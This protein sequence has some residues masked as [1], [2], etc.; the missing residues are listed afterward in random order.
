L[1]LAS[2][3]CRNCY[4]TSICFLSVKKARTAK[5]GIFYSLAFSVPKKGVSFTCNC[6]SVYGGVGMLVIPIS[7]QRSWGTVYKTS[8]IDAIAHCSSSPG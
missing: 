2:L 3:H 4:R 8:N 6:T 1:L 5:Q 7:I